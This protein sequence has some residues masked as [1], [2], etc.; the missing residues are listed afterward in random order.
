MTSELEKRKPKTSRPKKQAQRQDWAQAE[1]IRLEL[2]DAQKTEARQWV[3]GHSELLTLADE[4]IENGYKFTVKY[5]DYNN[6]VAVFLQPADGEH[7]NAGYILTGRGSTVASSLREV[8]YKHFVA[9][10]GD[11]STSSD[12]PGRYETDDTF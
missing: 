9:L 1:F 6:C 8:L 11:W 5:D 3:S 2:T 4:V 7:E 10:S 12:G